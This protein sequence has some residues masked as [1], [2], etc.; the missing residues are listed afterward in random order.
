MNLAWIAAP[1]WFSAIVYVLLGWVAVVALPQLVRQLGATGIG[2]L[3]LGGVF[4]SVGAAV[5]ALKRPDPAPAVFGY[6]EIFHALVIA[7]AISHYAVVAA[8]VSGS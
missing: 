5:Y 6:H 1:K 8:C 7:A 3:V 4:Y 2:L